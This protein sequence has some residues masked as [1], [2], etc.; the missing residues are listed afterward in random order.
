MTREPDGIGLDEVLEGLRMELASARAKAAGQDV[1]FP[2]ESLTVEL[3]AGVTRKA[4]GKAG[5]RVP[6]IQ[7]ELRA[8]AGYDRETMQT[9]TLVLGPPVDSTGRPIKVAQSTGEDK[10]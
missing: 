1:Q 5:F 6:L 8:S 4:D 10:L 3:K 9:V 2:V 7:A